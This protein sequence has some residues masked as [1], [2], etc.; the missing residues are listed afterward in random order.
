[1][2]LASSV[3]LA[4]LAVS[5]T[6]TNLATAQ[7]RIQDS[8]LKPGVYDKRVRPAGDIRA[9]GSTIVRANVYVRSISDLSDA[10]MS[11]KVQLTYRQQWHDHRLKFDDLGGQIRFLSLNDVSRLWIPDTFFIDER[12][13]HFHTVT[14]PNVLVRIYPDGSVLYSIRVSLK[15][16][17]PMNFKRYPF[18]EQQCQL[19]M[20]SYGHTANELFYLWKEGDPVQVTKYLHTPM[21]TL[22]RFR[23]DYCSTAMSTGNYSC[24][25]VA[26]EFERESGNAVVRVYVPCVML[27]IVSWIPLWLNI[28][29]SFV[30]LLTP[31]L[32][33]VVLA[34]GISQYNQNEVP[35]TPYTKAVDV[36][37]GICLT[38][39]FAVVLFVTTLDYMRRREGSGGPAESP[40]NG[41][42]KREIEEVADEATAASP[43]SSSGVSDKMKTWIQQKRTTAEKAD[44]VARI[45]FPVL[46]VLFVIIYF[47]IFTGGS[48][49]STFGAV[50][51]G[52]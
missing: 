3:L 32:V 51:Y 23:T 22:T 27:V 5:E 35:K 24:L 18:D 17:C 16:S 21:F 30:R 31:L 36:W 20:E 29:S 25:M 13:G 9:Q 14:Q 1:M 26:F 15:L 19:R 28:K 42:G 46:F 38:F 52:R 33:L 37:T 4:R 10:D 2:T 11:F 34:S 7:V 48:D 39:V 41:D 49:G 43:A 8:L 50:E 6:Q 44:I 47:S 45:V 40:T 12:E